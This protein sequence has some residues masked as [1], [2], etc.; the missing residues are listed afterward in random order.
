MKKRLLGYVLLLG[1]LLSTPLKAFISP[2]PEGHVAS[3]DLYSYCNGDPVNQY[4]ADGRL[5]T[6]FNSGLNGNISANAPTSSAFYF[7]NLIGGGVSGAG[8]GIQNGAGGTVNAL[9]LGNLKGAFGSDPSSFEYHSGQV[10][11][12]MLGGVAA[13]G[14]GGLAYNAVGGAAGLSSLYATTS[15]N[16]LYYGGLAAPV[17][18]NLG[19]AIT[20]DNG[21]A[22]VA[23]KAEAK[24][25]QV[26]GGYAEDAF[27]VQTIPRGTVLYGG[28]PAS[29]WFTDAATVQSSGLSQQRLW[30][31]LQVQASQQWGPRMNMNI[32]TVLEDITVPIGRALNNDGSGGGWQMFLN[33]KNSTAVLKQVGNIDLH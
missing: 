21:M 19:N 24:M 25:A 5:Q 11:G 9:S 26:V 2:D 16:A 1:L 6:G 14:T 3:M 31:S 12:A 13:I 32:Y 27:A 7:G 4:D 22:N 8:T 18:Y 15:A 33:Q 28:N 23:L 10:G 17:A 20:G 30:S 29:G